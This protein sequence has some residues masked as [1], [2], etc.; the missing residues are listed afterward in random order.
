MNL[1]SNYPTDRSVFVKTIIKAKAGSRCNGA[2][3]LIRRWAEPGLLKPCI[4][5]SRVIGSVD[6]NSWLGCCT[7]DRARGVLRSRDDR[8]QQ[9]KIS[10]HL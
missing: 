8:L 2:C 7:I 3:F 9:H 5:R 10:G 6:A 1:S 4:L